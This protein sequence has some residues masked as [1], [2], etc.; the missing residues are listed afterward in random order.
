LC[1]APAGSENV[2]I[3]YANRSVVYIKLGYYK[4][5]LANIQLARDNNYPTS[6]LEK[7]A[8]REH[9]ILKK[10][11]AGP[12][13]EDSFQQHKDAKKEFLKPT[14][15]ANDKYPCYVADCLKI[16]NSEEYGTHVRTKID[17]KVGTVVVAEK[18]KAAAHRPLIVYQR[19]EFCKS[20]NMLNLIPCDSCTKAM[21]CSEKCRQDDFEST[22]KYTCGIDFDDVMD[23]SNFKLFCIG[24][25]C[26]RSPTEFAEF[27]KETED[28]DEAAWDIDF[29]GLGQK[30][31]D[32]KLLQTVNSYKV[33][34]PLPKEKFLNYFKELALFTTKILKYSKFKDIMPSEDLK[35]VFRNFAFRQMLLIDHF[36]FNFDR[37]Q[38]QGSIKMGLGILFFSNLFNHSCTPNTYPF[39]DGSKMHHLVLRPIKKGEQ[40]FIA[41][42]KFYQCPIEERREIFLRKHYFICGCEACKNPSKYPLLPSLPV[43]NRQTLQKYSNLIPL[44][45]FDYKTAMKHYRPICKYLQEHDRDYPSMEIAIL[46]DLIERCLNAFCMVDDFSI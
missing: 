24:L 33:K 8:E 44:F 37:Y 4:T 27:L 2:G 26:F 21:Y 15:P 31:V 6:K 36:Y 19:C 1:Y 34:K 46:Y 5:A 9:N 25:N 38:P 18:H 3:A 20:G 12:S 11:R 45:K 42:Q 29:A 17:L 30:E 39:Y 23:H 14:L 13:K 28:S 41:Y 40:L 35:N 7:L 43:K 16:E 10:I 22:H 32:K